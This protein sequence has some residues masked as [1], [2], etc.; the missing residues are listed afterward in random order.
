M[1]TSLIDAKILSQWETPDDNLVIFDTR[2]AKMREKFGLSM[3][4]TPTYESTPSFGDSEELIS[5][6]EEMLDYV[7]P[8]PHELAGAV[9]MNYNGVWPEQINTALLEGASI[10]VIGRPNS[11]YG[12][13]GLVGDSPDLIA[14]QQLKFVDQLLYETKGTVIC[15]GKT[16]RMLVDKMGKEALQLG[17]FDAGINGV[18]ENTLVASFCDLLERIWAHGLTKKQGKSSLWSFVLQHQDL[19]KTCLST[20]ALSSSMLTPGDGRRHTI[21]RTPSLSYC[22]VPSP[23]ILQPTN[24]NDFACALSEIVETIQRE[25]GKSDD[26][27]VPVWSRSI[28]RAANFFADK[29]T[30]TPKDEI[31]G[32]PFATSAKRH[33]STLLKN[34]SSVSDF[35]SPNW[36]GEIRRSAESSDSPRRRSQSRP[37]SPETGARVLLAPLPTHIAYD[38]KNVLRMT[39]IKTDIGYARAFVRLALERKLLH[40]HLATLLANNH[41]L[42]E[43]YKPYAFVRC[44]D[45]REQFL[46]HILSLNAAQFRCFTNTFTKTKMDYQVVIVTG[47][48]RGSLPAVWVMH[49]NLGVLSTLRI[50]HSPGTEKPPNWYLEYIIVRNEITG[51]M[52]RFPCGRWFGQSAEDRR[53]FGNS[54]DVSL[55]R[56]LVAEPICGNDSADLTFGALPNSPVRGTR[57]GRVSS[58]SQTPQRD[59]SPSQSRTYS[60]TSSSKARVT[61]IQ[62][63]LGESVNS[64]VKYFYSEKHTKSELAYLLCGEHGL[65]NAIEQAF[66]FGRHTSVWLFRQPSPW[67]YIEKVCSWLMDVLRRRDTKW[68]PEQCELVTHTLKLVRKISNR[69]A[70][71]KDAKFHV[72]ILLMIRDHILSGFLQ[73]MAWTPI[74]AQLYDEVSFLR[75][76]VHLTYLSRLLDSL[77][78]F[79]FSLDPSLTYGV[80]GNSI[81]LKRFSAAFFYGVTS[82]IVVFVNKI[83]LTNFR[84]PSFLVVGFGQMVATVI[85]LFSARALH[86]V[87][88][89][90]FDYSIPRK[91]M[92]LPLFFVVNLVSGLGGTQLINLPMFTV[93][94]RF[95]ILMTMVLEYYILGVSATR[96]VRISVCL[97]IAGSIIAALF[98]LTFDLWGYILIG[99]N[100]I[101]TAALGV[102]TKQKLEAK[103]LGKYG[104][105]FYNSLFML[106]PT[107]LLTFYTGDM[108]RALNFMLSS[109]MSPSIWACFFVSCVCGFILNYSLVLCTHFNSALTTTCVGPIK[110]II[111]TYAGMFSSGDYIFHW[112]NFI[113]INISV[114]GSILYTYATF[115]KK[116]TDQRILTV[117]PSSKLESQIKNLLRKTSF[118]QVHRA[119][120]NQVVSLNYLGDWGTQFALIATYWPKVRPSDS[121]WDSCSD[122]DK[123]RA[124]TDCYIVA[125][126]K[127]KLDEE[128]QVEVRKNFAEMENGIIKWQY[129]SENVIAARRLVADLIKNNTVRRTVNGL[130]IVDIPNDDLNEEIASILN[131]DKIYHADRYLYVVDRAQRKHFEA[132]RVILTKIGRDDLALKVEHI[133]YGRVKGLSTRLGRTEIVEEII[134]RGKELALRFMKNSKTFKLSSEE[135]EEVAHK[136][137]LSTVIFNEVKRAKS[138]EYE[139]SFKNAFDLDHNN[140]LSLQV[141]HSRLCSIEAKNHELLPLLDKCDSIPEETPDFSKLAVHLSQFSTVIHA[142]VEQSESCHLV[143]YLLELS[144]HI[145]KVTSQARIKGQPVEVAVPRLLLLSASRAVLNEG[146][147]LLGASPVTAM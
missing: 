95:S 106:L 11:T 70:L 13:T 97:M 27:N 10:S 3:V 80:M 54:C 126:K 139:F 124:I 39:E 127:R 55:E 14:K 36:N 47:G 140:A 28:L 101:C 105:M 129:E 84:F 83:L 58:R 9:S 48:W 1:F 128:F 88:F 35:S 94:R 12:S 15:L 107:V 7:V 102:Y 146:M 114:M 81:L 67:D 123:I 117:V 76:P 22:E 143:V 26:D 79:N 30:T 108:N 31:H 78:E 87:S 72:F 85:V 91:I 109:Q 96:A 145:G 142:A 51:Q 65:I 69:T 116:S 8:G 52:Y 6:R 86:L 134:S 71:G 111:V 141:R 125:N 147:S 64:L 100:D 38:L 24:E 33:S 135:E 2:I 42:S 110:N 25:F 62:Q 122:V 104:L 32:V 29:L 118:S 74:T 46:Y 23:V 66:Q 53:W 90:S 40:K 120:G 59:R 144:H 103:E 50:G 5:K 41:L 132:L 138:A 68:T 63:V 37:R 137:S 131:R 57:R 16:K 113:G 89:P 21:K 115:R 121:F 130:W 56:L 98:D 73:V 133:P 18:E 60:S 99:V 49:K 4:R 82:I 45:E 17:H 136:L 20:K 19:E 44:E 93:L 92:P 43:L 75:A 77:N 119:V 112:T 61:E 34:S